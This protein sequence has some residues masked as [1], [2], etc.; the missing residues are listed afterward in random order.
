[1][2]SVIEIDAAGRPGEPEVV[3]EAP[4]HL[5]YPFVFQWA[6]DWWMVPESADAGR[7][8]LWRCEAWPS[9][10]R[11]E[12]VLLDDLRAFDAT[13]H[14]MDDAWWMFASIERDA[15]PGFDELHVFRAQTPLGPFLRHPRNPV[16]RD[17]RCARPA[18]RMFRDGDHWIRPAQDCSRRYGGA[19]V[20]RRIDRLDERGL[21]ETTIR[22][23]EPWAD[24]VRATH[25]WNRAGALVV[26]DA[27]FRQRR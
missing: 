13:L 6:D 21:L 1:V 9:R 18:G 23:I 25:T 27:V 3:I 4:H 17:V 2:I 19:T 12:R 20:L 24:D 10:W 22:R 14:E 7:V 15:T 16:L 5:S 11:R 26:V 8:E